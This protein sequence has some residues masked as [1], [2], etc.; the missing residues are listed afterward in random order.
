VH[1]S[2]WHVFLHTSCMC[3]TRTHIHLK[4]SRRSIYDT[5]AQR[6]WYPGCTSHAWMPLTNSSQ[7][8]LS[9]TD[10]RHPHRNRGFQ[11]LWKPQLCGMQ[12]SLQKLFCRIDANCDGS[13]NWDEFSLYMLL[14][15]Q[16]KAA[17]AENEQQRELKPPSYI[18]RVHANDAHTKVID[19][20]SLIPPCGG[21]SSRYATGARDGAVKLWDSK[22][23]NLRVSEC[24]TPP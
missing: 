8:L 20:C 7:F 13:V 23:Q 14:A 2:K 15:N 19:C 22:V 5:C 21:S 4:D 24:C 1:N 12:A 18:S 16:G 11:G 3:D 10:C 6:D 17:I 9:Y